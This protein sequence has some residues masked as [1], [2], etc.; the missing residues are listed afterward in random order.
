MRLGAFVPL[1]MDRFPDA[2]FTTA[3]LEAVAARCVKGFPTYGE[4][5]AYLADWWRANRPAPPALPAPPPIRQRAEPTPDEIEHVTLVTR[6]T[7]A[8]LRSIAQPEVAYRHPGARYLSPGMLDLLNPLPNGRMRVHGA[9]HS[10]AAAPPAAAPYGAGY[11]P[12]S[13]DD[14]AP[15]DDPAAA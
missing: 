13:N 11:W 14:P 10:P 5:A 12:A 15:P 6:E 3:S 1:L 4:L 2:A 7:V 9:V 8:A